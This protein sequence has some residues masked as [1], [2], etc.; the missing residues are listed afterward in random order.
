MAFGKDDGKNVFAHVEAEPFVVSVDKSVLG[1]ISGDPADWREL[2]VFRFKP[3]DII[4]LN[5][6]HTATGASVSIVRSGTVWKQSA[7]MRDAGEVNSIHAQ[8]LV[9][10][11]AGLKAVRWIPG[12]PNAALNRVTEIIAFT[13]TGGKSHKLL[14]GALSPDGTRPARLDGDTAAFAISGPD[15]S[16]LRLSLVEP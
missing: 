16:A 5:V 14:L 4:A 7:E 10:T 6:T 11:L 12:D 9:N 1:E 3:D 13:T 8:S 2:P 15:E